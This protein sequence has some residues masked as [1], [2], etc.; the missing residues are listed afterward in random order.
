MLAFLALLRR[1]LLIAGRGF[2]SNLIQAMIIPA[3]FLFIFGKVLPETGVATA[4]YGALLLPG[5]VAMTLLMTALMNVTLPLV[6]DIGNE[7]EMED[8]LLAPLPT[9]LVAVEKV[10]FAALYAFITALFVFPL[11]YLILSNAFQ[12]RWDAIGLLIG[13]MVLSSFAGACLGLTLG[14]AVQP[15]QI[16]VLNAVILMPIIFTGCIYFSWSALSSIRWFQIVTLF[17][18]L[19]Y[20]S[21]GLRYAM[22]PGLHG[23]PLDTLGIFWVLLGLC[24]TTVLFLVLGIRGFIKRAV[25]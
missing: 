21:E 25:K 9:A 15:E 2:I 11:A 13:I 6:L 4:S 17:N 8:R 22:T 24:I 10:L 7:R 1:D 18:P 3:L 23:H 14:T 12:M 20:S 5:M 19:T 16:G